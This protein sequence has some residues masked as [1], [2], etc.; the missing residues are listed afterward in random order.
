MHSSRLREDGALIFRREYRFYPGTDLRNM[1][2]LASQ[3]WNNG[4]V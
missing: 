4:D 1:N 2:V 3:S